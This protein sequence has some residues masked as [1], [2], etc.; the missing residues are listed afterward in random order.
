MIHFIYFSGVCFFPVCCVCWAAAVRECV[1]VVVWLTGRTTTCE[2]SVWTGVAVDVV[3]TDRV[4]RNWHKVVWLSEIKDQYKSRTAYFVVPG[5]DGGR[6]VVTME[7]VVATLPPCSLASDVRVLVPL[8]SSSA[9]STVVCEDT[10]SLTNM[11]RRYMADDKLQ[12]L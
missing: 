4:T 12:K 2:A 6:S 7:T 3:V 8:S 10:N 9:A 1:L 5:V 11:M